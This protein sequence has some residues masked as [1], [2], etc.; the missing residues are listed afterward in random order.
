MKERERKSEMSRRSG[1]VTV[2]RKMWSVGP[3]VLSLPLPLLVKS[4]SR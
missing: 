4:F 1:I 3:Y 2:D